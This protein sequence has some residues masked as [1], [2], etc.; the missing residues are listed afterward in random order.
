M[1]LHRQIAE[2]H[3]AL[4]ELYEQLDQTPKRKRIHNPP[5][6]RVVPTELQRHKAR[7]ILKEITPR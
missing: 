4:A 5:A 6:P 3:R 7:K 1:S 2:H